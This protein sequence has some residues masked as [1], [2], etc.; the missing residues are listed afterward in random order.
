MLLN[1]YVSVSVVWGIVCL[2]HVVFLD[3]RL[4]CVPLLSSNMPTVYSVRDLM[5]MHCINIILLSMIY[6]RNELDLNRIHFFSPLLC[7]FISTLQN[8]PETFVSGILVQID[9]H[10]Q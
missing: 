8:Y 7:F 10:G 1:L 2:V 3:L 5:Y 4:L 9:E 6:F